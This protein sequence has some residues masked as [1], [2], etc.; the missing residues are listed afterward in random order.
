[1]FKKIHEKLGSAGLIIAVVALVAALTGTA[2]AAAGLN[3]KQ[4]KEVTKIAKKF[5]GKPGATGP[6][7]PQGPAGAAGAKGDAGAPGAKGATGPEGPPGKDGATGPPGPTE[8]VLPPE[9]TSTGT[10]GF[11]VESSEG[12]NLPVAISFPLRVIPAPAEYNAPTNLIEEGD[13]PT[14]RCPGSVSDPQ[15]A[16]GEFCLYATVLEGATTEGA[17]SVNDS[18]F[19]A[20]RTSGLV[21]P[22]GIETEGLARGRGTWAVTACPP[23]PTEEEEEEGVESCP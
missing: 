6:A 23:P 19:S 18:S 11:A 7:G 15:A 3:S 2:L 14:A 22:F 20:D 4:K 21:F 12:I 5:A 10:W 16:P 13:P 1:M 9:E 8:T 17:A